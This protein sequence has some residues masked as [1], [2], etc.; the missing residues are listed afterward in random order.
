MRSETKINV[1]GLKPGDYAGICA[2]QDTYGIIGVT[3]DDDKKYIV[4]GQGTFNEQ[5]DGFYEKGPVTEN[6]RVSEALTSDEVTIKIEYDFL[7]SATSIKDL[8]NFY[9]SL[10]NGATW[11]KLG[12]QLKLTNS[13]LTVFMG[14]RTYL[15][16]YSTK[17]TGGYADF[18][19][20]KIY[21]K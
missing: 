3:C 14:A 12:K 17:E 10:D 6:V 5:S 2:F 9:Y 11:T 13:H 16:M 8:V 1:A 4:Q 7:Y 21:D 20:Y 19:Y 15:F 18:D